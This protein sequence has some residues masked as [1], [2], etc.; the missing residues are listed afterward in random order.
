MWDVIQTAYNHNQIYSYSN[1]SATLRNFYTPNNVGKWVGGV[2][3][4]NGKI[5]CI[6]HNATNVLI[7]DPITD[8]DI[9]SNFGLTLG[10]EGWWGGCLGS[11]GKIYG[12]PN[13]SNEVLV[14]N[15]SNNTAELTDFSLNLA[16]FG[17]TKWVGGVVGLNGKIYCI[18]TNA[19]KILVI[20]PSNNTAELTDFGL[21][22]NGSGKWWGGAM[23]PDGKIYCIP[24]GASDF[25]IIDTINHSASRKS[26]GLTIP[27]NFP[28]LGA[29]LGSDGK[30]YG[31]PFGQQAP[32]VLII[33]TDKQLATIND[34]GL[35]LADGINKYVGGCLGP[36]GKIYC[37]PESSTNFLIIDPVKQIAVRDNLGVSITGLPSNK[38][39]SCVL[40]DNGTIYMIPFRKG[41]VCKIIH[42]SASP[43]NTFIT[44]H[45]S[46]NK[47]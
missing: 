10:N 23:G 25:L 43:Y 1:P 16:E 30:I 21:N 35:N 28:W 18:P 2:V 31:V 36:D 14:I 44:K 38:Y 47:F 11:D 32:G 17:N 4:P 26:L 39:R 33:D 19:T 5:Y 7:I 34:F 41:E 24:V 6:P 42:P 13:N 9:S 3:A 46:L 45:P 37:C 22:L 12:I 20:N 29:V 40:S 8:T 27:G 15:P